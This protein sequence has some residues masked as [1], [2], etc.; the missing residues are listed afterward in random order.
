MSLQITPWLLQCCKEN[1]KPG[2]YLHIL[3][4]H[5]VRNLKGKKII[6]PLKVGKDL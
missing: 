6:E 5:P 3:T 1:G 4:G 2:A